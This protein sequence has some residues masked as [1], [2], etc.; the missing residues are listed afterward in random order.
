MVTFIEFLSI[1]F[2]T[3]KLMKMI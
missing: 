1:Y 3:P 2:I